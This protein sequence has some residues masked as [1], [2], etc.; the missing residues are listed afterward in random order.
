MLGFDMFLQ[1]KVVRGLI[2]TCCA[3]KFSLFVYACRM[4]CKGRRGSCFE[5]TLATVESDALM[6]IFDVM[7]QTTF[8]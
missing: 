7:F 1:Q 5:V 2:V 3:F 8:M 6:S 4:S